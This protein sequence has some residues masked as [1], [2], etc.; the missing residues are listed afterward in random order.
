[1]FYIFQ[2]YYVLFGKLKKSHL[3][4]DVNCNYTLTLLM[5]KY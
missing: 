1:M 2:K 3:K 4:Y 5:V